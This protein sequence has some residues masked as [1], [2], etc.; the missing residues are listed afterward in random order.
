M[1]EELELNLFR[2][3]P[4]LCCDYKCD[5]KDSCF[6]WGFECGDGWYELI[7]STLWSIDKTS[8][9]V[10]LNVK[11]AQI[12]SKFG[13]LTIYL[14]IGAGPSGAKIQ[15]AISQI[16]SFIEIASDVSLSI[17][18]IS[19]LPASQHSISGWIYTI[20]DSE[21]EEIRNQK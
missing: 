14:D 21:A 9:S 13:K 18:E 10:N 3:Y 6:A 16:Y 8:K 4:D 17:S 15:Q 12:K 11:L 19:G 7:D 20:T 2:K 1:K 5:P